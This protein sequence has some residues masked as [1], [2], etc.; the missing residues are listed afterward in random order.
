[1]SGFIWKAAGVSP[2]DVQVNLD[3]QGQGWFTLTAVTPS[4]GA[5]DLKRLDAVDADGD[6]LFRVTPNDDLMFKLQVL[7][8]NSTA[9]ASD[10]WL[11]VQQNGVT[12]QCVDSTGA[13]QNAQGG[14]FSAVQLG[15]VSPAKAFV[16]NFEVW[17]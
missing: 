5:T 9:A 16:G 7:C 4:G 12:L 3:Q 1:M 10:V 15:S 13:V 2:V 11:T 8:A 6:A 14:G 17:E